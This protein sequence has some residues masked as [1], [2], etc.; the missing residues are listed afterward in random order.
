[1]KF[2]PNVKWFL[3]PAIM[4]ALAV[5]VF[6]VMMVLLLKGM[7]HTD[8]RVARD[9]QPHPIAL[10]GTE[11]R[12]VW[13]PLVESSAD[14]TITDL[15]SAEELTMATPLAG[16][17]RTFGSVEMR[18]AWTFTPH[19]TAVSITCK[20]DGGGDVEIGKAPRFASFFGGM[21]AGIVGTFLLGGIGA[22]WLVVLLI[23]FF[24]R[25]KKVA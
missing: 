16:Y 2:R 21:F 7:S 5:T 1:M 9:G 12:M 22:L 19:S 24:S 13:E 3:G 17:T 15:E 11:P 4:L 6:V 25:P 8:A 18:G 20:A 14:C 23:L 10:E